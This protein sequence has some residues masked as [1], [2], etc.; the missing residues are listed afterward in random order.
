MSEKCRAGFRWDD[1]RPL[2]DFVLNPLFQD[3]DDVWESLNH[4]HNHEEHVP[5]RDR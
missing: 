5:D 2:L 3:K 1:Q 4:D